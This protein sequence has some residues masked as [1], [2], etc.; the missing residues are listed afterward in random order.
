[1]FWNVRGFGYV[2]VLITLGL[3]IKYGW[4]VTLS[5]KKVIEVGKKAKKHT[6]SF[7]ANFVHFLVK[8]VKFLTVPARSCRCYGQFDIGVTICV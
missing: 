3:K 2:I 6:F 7:K 8:K 5:T 1:M 4:Y